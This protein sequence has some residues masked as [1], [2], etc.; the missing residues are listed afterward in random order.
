M[1]LLSNQT[2]ER[3]L[4]RV[5][6][7]VFVD[8]NVAK[9][10]VVLFPHFGDIAQQAHG[11]DQQIVKVERVVRVQA[12][13]VHLVNRRHRGPALVDILRVRREGGGIFS[14][15][16]GRANH[17]LRRARTEILFVETKLFNA[18]LDQT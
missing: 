6:V 3:E 9:L 12:V 16:F 18:L 2:D 14:A 7:L 11:L 1:R 4:E 5:R 10:V 15:I 13:F 17:R 8:K